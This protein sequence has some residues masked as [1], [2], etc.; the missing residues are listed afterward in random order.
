MNSTSP[1]GARAA[2]LRCASTLAVLIGL[3]GANASPP[4]AA[5]EDNAATPLLS[6]RNVEVPFCYLAGGERRWPFLS[7]PLGSTDDISF[8]LLRDGNILAEGA[9]I[10]H[11]G[12][13]IS[14]LDRCW[15]RIE[16][17]E[18]V[19][20]AWQLRI[21]I[22]REEAHV[23]EQLITIRRAPQPRPV[24]Y[25]ADLVD[26]LIRIFWDE[27]GQQFRPVQKDGFD[28]YF[29]RLQA[30]GISRLIVWQSPFPLI[31]D[32]ENYSAEDWQRYELQA[33]AIL[34]S[35]E[36][37]EAMRASPGQK[38]YDWLGMLMQLRLS[39]DFASLFTTSAAE[40]QIALSASYRPF[41]PAGSKYYEVPALDADGSFLWTFY[42]LASPAVNYHADELAFV[43]YR[44]ILRAAGY[45][46]QAQLASIRIGNLPSA[47][48]L[49]RRAA[50][51]HE[52]LRLYASS[53]PP[54]D[55]QSFV[56]VRQSGPRFE[57]QRYAKVRAAAE[58][59]RILIRDFQ[60][61]MDEHGGL[62]IDGVHAPDSHPYLVIEAT[63]NWAKSLELPVDLDIKLLAQA[64]NQLGRANTFISLR[65]DDPS[66]SRT[67]V[68][69]IPPDGNY[70]T[71]FFAIE[72]SL[73]FFRSAGRST[74]RWGEA[75][76][77]IHQGANACAEMIDFEQ[78]AARRY[79]VRELRTILAHA[80]F[81]EIFINTRTHTQLAA[82]MADG[83]DGV[84][85]VA[86]YRLAGKNYFHLGI[87]RAYAPRSLAQQPEIQQLAGDPSAVEQLTTW[88]PG[89]W[90]N[91]C[92]STGCAFAWRFHRNRAVARGVRAL[93]AE[94]EAELPRVRIRAVIPPSEDVE[95]AVREAL[96][97]MPHPNGG[98]YGASYYQ[99]VWSSL[100]H[101]PAIGEGMAM[102]DL[103]GL[104]VEP[105]FLGI[106]YLPD[107]GPLDI[108]V[109][110]S[111]ADLQDNRGSA[112][113]GPRSFFYEAQETL[114][115]TDAPAAHQRRE[116]IIRDLLA[117][118]EEIG[119]VLLYEAADW[120][121]YLPLD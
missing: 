10:E 65:G 97:Q 39:N 78:P 64:G 51:G 79:A 34:E 3:A 1:G 80:P 120:T 116:E 48:D 70:R 7:R 38:A 45:D 32:R 60:M 52:D 100:N 117:H 55:E 98:R 76:L 22:R 68:A 57:L 49:V 11:A 119:E 85:T 92:Q 81:D 89:E 87:D 83:A 105:V 24:S 108:F 4:C 110:H 28:Q 27:R 5:A 12:L 8:E 18:D 113:R 91:T 66:A 21:K 71:E 104:S 19:E 94:L 20:Q 44:E 17:A 118:D 54:L 61:R 103:T 114:R 86:H 77:V 41:E 50:E 15:L 90:L 93:L 13:K 84:Q 69:G 82:S 43:H 99:H 9:T 26:D 62:V 14:L 16:A 25:V 46:Q 121:Y 37:N 29:R 56:L 96:E 59:K 40:H 47:S 63:S 107:P 106:R 23:E 101:I 31:V 35:A 109:R 67:R 58:S 75:D 111:V 6:P 36:L 115:A 95:I 72:N 112:F 42:P 30:Q 73:D 74:W 2:L 88:Q 33:R 102:V 53:I